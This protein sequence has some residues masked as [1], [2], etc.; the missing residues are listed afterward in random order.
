MKLILFMGSA[1]VWL[2]I[3]KA[4]GAGHYQAVGEQGGSHSTGFIYKSRNYHR[5]VFQQAVHTNAGNLFSLHH[6]CCV[7]LNY[8]F[9]TR[10][11]KKVA[12]STAGAQSSYA[13]LLLA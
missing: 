2:Y 6:K 9:H 4:S 5:L 7:L 11:G 1:W 3:K 12:F 10:W 13:H 8:L